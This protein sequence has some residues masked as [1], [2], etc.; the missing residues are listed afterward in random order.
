MDYAFQP[1]IPVD[2]VM[3]LVGIFRGTIERDRGDVLMICG[4]ILGEVGALAKQGGLFFTL[5]D[6]PL[7]EGDVDALVTV[8]DADPNFDIVPWIPVILKLIELLIKRRG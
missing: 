8:C 3:T 6:E 5:D 2:R 1:R 4:S 7:E